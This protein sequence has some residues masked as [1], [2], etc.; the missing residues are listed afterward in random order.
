[1]EYVPDGTLEERLGGQ[2][3]PP[4]EAARLIEILASAMHEAH[5]CGI[6]HRDL[7]PGNVLLRRQAGRPEGSGLESGVWTSSMT[8][9][10]A[11][12]CPKITDFGLAKRLGEERGLTLTQSVLGTPY[13]MAPEQARGDSRTSPRPPTSTRWVPCS[14]SS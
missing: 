1:M 10:P 5:R 2:P 11:S 9:E 14:T 8:E 7:K 4:A 13:Y 6:V 3:Q 12:F